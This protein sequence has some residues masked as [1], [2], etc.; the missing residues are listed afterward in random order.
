[1]STYQFFGQNGQIYDPLALFSAK[2][3]PV[4]GAVLKDGKAIIGFTADASGCLLIDGQQIIY[5]PE[6]PHPYRLHRGDSLTPAGQGIGFECLE[7]LLDRICRPLPAANP[8][9]PRSSAADPPA[10]A[11]G[12]GDEALAEE[13]L[14]SMIGP[15]D[16]GFV[17][18]VQRYSREYFDSFTAFLA[19]MKQETPGMDGFNAFVLWAVALLAEMRAVNEKL[20]CELDGCR[21]ML[22]NPQ[23]HRQLHRAKKQPH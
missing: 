16:A 8:P 17:R 21:L 20:A 15:A 4:S 6:A 23:F 10:T 19:A 2:A 11:E 18:Q 1:M 12:S 7:A 9:P 14:Q 5:R 13:G 3:R 22:T